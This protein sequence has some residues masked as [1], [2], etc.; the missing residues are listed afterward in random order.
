MLFLSALGL[1][2]DAFAVVEA[3]Y[4]S[5]GFIVSPFRNTK[6]MGR[7]GRL[8]DRRTMGLFVPATRL[9]RRDPRFPKLINELGLVRYWK[10]SGT[11]PDYQLSKNI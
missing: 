8:E 6:A 5:R 7:Y 9:M 2:D 10:E 3:N 1:V 4:F 11:R